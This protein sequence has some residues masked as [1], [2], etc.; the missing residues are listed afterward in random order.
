MFDINFSTVGTYKVSATIR[1]TEQN[2][3]TFTEKVV[4]QRPLQLVRKGSES[5]L[6]VTDQSGE[7]ILKNT[8]DRDLEAYR[9]E[10]I[11]IPQKLAFDATD[12]RVKNEGYEL[13]E[14]LWKIGDTERK[15]FKIEQ[16]FVEEKRYEI[17][18]TYVFVRTG[19]TE[20]YKVSEKIILEGKS[21]EIMPALQISSLGNDDLDNLF[22]T[23]DVK[24]DAS[25][26]KVRSGKISQFIY[27]FGE[28]KP[29]SEGEAVKIYRYAI[30]GEYTVKVTA[31]KNDG[32]K[33]SISR[34]LII[35]EIP[36]KLALSTSVSQ[37]ITGKTVEFMT[38][39]TVGQIESYSW[40]FG[41][42]T[43][44]SQEPNPTHVFD[45]AGN[46][47]VKLSAT[48]ADGTIRNAELDF[49]VAD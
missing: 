45:K 6:S 5:L 20:E 34:N 33:E 17:V 21:R 36:R 49:V 44:P 8:Y 46:Y 22:A 39:G 19:T 27:D 47:T 14:V 3:V 28:G 15:G 7:M 4:I 32:T 48:Y 29:P 13:K 38:S 25:A 41:D 12:V 16:D 35:K 2:T 1:D 43:A 37:G 30:P 9:I 10:G 40:D 42:G 18:S 11:Q 26:S 31:V 24:F 23:V